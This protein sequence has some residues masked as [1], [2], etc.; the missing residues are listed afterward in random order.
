VT[1][2]QYKWWL[3]TGTAWTLLQDWTTSNTYTWTPATA[4]SYQLGVWAKPSTTPGDIWAA[5]G[6]LPFTVT[7]S[8]PLAL[9]SFT[10][11]PASPQGAGTPITV[12]AT[13]S[14]GLAPYQYKWWLYTGSTWT[15]LQD[16]TTSHTYTWTPATAG[17]YQLGVWVRNSGSTADTWGVYGTLPFVVR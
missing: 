1:S 12:T 5:Y 6:T 13:A 3:Y 9:A 11:T 10:A 16:W 8:P 4:G 17:S 15:L 2:P 14:G 7:E